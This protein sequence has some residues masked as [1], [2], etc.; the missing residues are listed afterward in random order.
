MACTTYPPECPE[1]YRASFHFPAIDNHAHPLL[2]TQHRSAIAFEGLLSEAQ[3]EA[4][5]DAVH[6]LACYR[7]T[8][9]LSK[10]YNLLPEDGTEITWDD[11]KS[12]RNKFDY[13]ELCRTCL[14]PT[15]IQCI[16]ID[17]GLGGVDELAEDYRW[18]D[19]FT[20]SPTKRIVRIET[21]AEVFMINIFWFHRKTEQKHRIF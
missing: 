21:L 8:A 13:L 15:R 9:Q 12:A 5:A 6:T 14:Q 18:H 1:L 7:A 11:V 3:D 2:S 4:I 16:L 20:H 17:D 10:L 19:Q